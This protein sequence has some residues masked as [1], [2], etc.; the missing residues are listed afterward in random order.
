VILFGSYA[1]GEPKETS[2]VDLL[3][4]MD[5]D[6][7]PVDKALEI[8]KAINARDYP[9]EIDIILRTPNDT[10]RRYRGFDP[11]IRHALNNGQVLY[12]R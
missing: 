9:F 5:F 10:V 8:R 4:V 3:V 2:D 7:P 11:L 6:M 12:E 1:Y